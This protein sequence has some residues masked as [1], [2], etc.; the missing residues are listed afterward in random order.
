MKKRIIIIS[1]LWGLKDAQWLIH[2]QELLNQYE[3]KIYDACQIGGVITKNLNQNEIHQQF[4]D[5]GIAKAAQHI[6]QSEHQSQIF[7]GCSIG[8]LIAWKAGLLGMPMEKLIAISSLL[9][10]QRYV[11]SRF[12]LVSVFKH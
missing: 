1:D 3:I 6:F 12:G 10:R 5:F 4:L 2:F 8:G 9:W 11:S 7:I